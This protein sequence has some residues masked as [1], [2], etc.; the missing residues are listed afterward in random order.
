MMP[1]WSMALF[2]S[3]ARGD[4]DPQ[5]DV[6]ILFITDE[7]KPRLIN[8]NRMSCSFYP[9]SHLLTKAKQGDL[10]VLHLVREAKVIYDDRDDFAAMSRAFRLKKSYDPVVEQASSLGRFMLRYSDGF[11]DAALV[12]RRIAWCVRTILIARAAEERKAI[13]AANALAEFANT[14]SVEQLI[15]NKGAPVLDASILKGFSAF[16]DKWGR[17]GIEPEAPAEA[18]LEY[19]KRTGNSVGLRTYFASRD[20]AA[21]VYE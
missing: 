4:D 21:E 19:F 7:E 6:D 1:L 9:S 18:Y 8:S 15:R 11:D 20:T 14:R 3:R 13:F 16:L 5:S 10:F 2:G 12:N 17:S